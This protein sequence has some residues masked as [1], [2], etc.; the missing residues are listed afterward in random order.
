MEFL[1]EL[2]FNLSQHD[3]S[4]FTRRTAKGITIILVYVD[5]I[6]VT[7]SSLELISETK[8]SLQQRFKMKDL[9]E[10][11]SHPKTIP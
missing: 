10:L 6:L 5:D 11:M 7:G 1:Q 4:L 3:H 9:G 8:M 2:G